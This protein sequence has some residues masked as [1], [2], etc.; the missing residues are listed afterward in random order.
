LGVVLGDRAEGIQSH[1]QGNEKAAD[2]FLVY[3]LQQGRG[4][5]QTGRR[6]RGAARDFRIDGLIPLRVL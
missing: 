1:V 2:A 5:V 3:L 4:K 6:R